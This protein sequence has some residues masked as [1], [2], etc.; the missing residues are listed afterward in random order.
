MLKAFLA[1]LIPVLLA[2]LMM[3]I[4]LLIVRAGKPKGGNR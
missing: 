3:G 4:A 1:A 2:V